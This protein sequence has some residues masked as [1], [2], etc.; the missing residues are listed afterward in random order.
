MQ[1]KQAM[2]GAALAVALA[3]TASAAPTYVGSWTVGDGPRWPTVPVAYTGQEAAA[4]LFGGTPEDYAISTLGTNPGLIDNMAW[5]SKWGGGCGA[6]PCGFIVAEDFEISTGGLYKTTGDTSAYV[7]D[8]AVGARFTN[9]AFRLDDDPV[10][11][12]EPAA[13]ALFGAGLVGL[14]ALRRRRRG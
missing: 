7:N 2:M 6:F 10:P 14:A 9:Y 13:L 11:V 3:G 5:V 1:L 4:L 12:P 8:W